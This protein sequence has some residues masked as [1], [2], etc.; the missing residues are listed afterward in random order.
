MVGIDL[1]M[2]GLTSSSRRTLARSPAM[3]FVRRCAGDGLCR[4]LAIAVV[5]LL[6]FVTIDA[7]RAD[8]SEAPDPSASDGQSMAERVADAAPSA[9][10]A[11][12]PARP[13]LSPKVTGLPSGPAGYRA[14]A[15]IEA[16]RSGLPGEIADAVMQVE[17]SYNPNAIGGAGEI[18]LMQ[19]LPSTARMLGFSGTNADLAVPA[20]NIH[21]GVAYLSQA[22]RLAGQDL[23]TAVMKYRAGHG[24]TRFSYL[25][26]DYC[27]AVRRKLAARGY[28]ITGNVPVATFGEAAR[29]RFGG[30]AAC[31]KKCLAGSP[32]ARVNFAALNN[33]L[34]QIVVRTNTQA[35][36]IR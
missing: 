17:S 5:V 2:A 20:T 15:E 34:S 12:P 36:S 14:I 28:P 24:E 6:A 31:G 18:G 1:G 26:V 7:A 27:L 30:G 33:Q 10:D 13:D 23:C 4:A 25:S 32:L 35:L 21:Y 8:P 19:L 3:A 9:G 16:K 29:G 22:W 11:L